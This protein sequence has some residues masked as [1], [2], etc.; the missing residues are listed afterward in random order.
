MK[1]WIGMK[2]E[3]MARQGLT[4]INGRG[5]YSL[6]EKGK[7]AALELLKADGV[8]QVGVLAIEKEPDPIG[9]WVTESLRIEAADKWIAKRSELAPTPDHVL[10]SLLRSQSE[11]ARKN[12]ERR[13]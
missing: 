2:L 9:S 10:V 12:L 6:T 5:N 4:Q 7:S 3:K 13:K 11:H 8:L 1:F